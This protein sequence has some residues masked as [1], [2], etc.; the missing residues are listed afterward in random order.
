MHWLRR[1]NRKRTES[2]T[3]SPRLLTPRVVVRG[4][5]GSGIQGGLI[6]RGPC[7]TASHRPFDCVR[8]A[9]GGAR[10]VSPKS[11]SQIWLRMDGDIRI[12]DKV[13]DSALDFFR[14]SV[15]FF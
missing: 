5:D 8:E 14:K 2:L 13:L 11:S 1:S 9:H 3:P 7:R 15:G 12:R 10:R 4:D 6:R